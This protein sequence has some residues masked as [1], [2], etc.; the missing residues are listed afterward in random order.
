MVREAPLTSPLGSLAGSLPRLSVIVRIVGGAP[1]LRRCLARLTPQAAGPS[2]EIVVPHD[3]TVGG[4]DQLR[5]DFPSVR[6]L[7]LG[8]VRTAA[9]PG[10]P[11]ALHELTERRAA[12][13]LRAARGEVLGLIED[14]AAPAADWCEQVLRAHQLPHGVIGGAVEH[15]ASN[16]LNWAIYFI[17][18]SRYQRPLPE[19]PTAYLTDANVSYKRAA[20]EGVEPLWAERYNEVTVHWALAERGVALWQR[21]QIVVHHHRGRLPFRATAVERIAWG[22]HFAARR[23]RALTGPVRLGYV[24]AG[25]LIPAVLL[26]RTAKRVFAGRRNRVAFV[27]ALPHLVAMTWLWGLGELGGYLTGREYSL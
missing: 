16:P 9:R 22:W 25:P 24:V 2:I 17:D 6:F 10:T 1:F 14:Y 8:T 12:A 21:P 26:G 18:F 20:L 13:G 15:A 4:L 7:D 19:G 3:A 23:T 5:T 11:G 27:G